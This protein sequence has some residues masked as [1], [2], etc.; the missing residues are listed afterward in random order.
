MPAHTRRTFLTAAAGAGALA[1]AGDPLAALR[2]AASPAAPPPIARD[3][4][5]VQGIASGE[6]ATDGITLWTRLEGLEQRSR[7][8][9]EISPDADFRRVIYRKTVVAEQDADFTIHHRATPKALRPGEEWHYRFFTCDQDSP[10]GRFR[11][12]VPADSQEPI[13]IGFYSCQ[14][15]AAGYYTAHAGLMNEP[16]LD[17]VVCLGDYIYERT[18]E[19]AIP[20]RRDRTGA[21]R[22]SLVETLPE[23]REKY[24][25]YHQDPDLLA[26]R[27]RF[28]M[29]ATWD[30]HE[31]KNN[32]AGP[33]ETP[34]PEK[35][36]PPVRRVSYA[37]RQ[38]NGWR[39]FFEHL[40]LRRTPGDPNRIYGSQRLGAN[41]ELM[42]LDERQYRDLQPCGGREI[43]PCPEQRNLRTLL[44]GP[45]K[46]WF[47]NA[48]AGSGATW[49]LVGNS[50]MIMSVDV[51]AGNSVN[52][53][54][55]DGYALEREEIVRF[56][57]ERGV[58]GVSFITGD[59]H[60]FFAG[61]VSPSGKAS[62][63]NGF[64]ATEFVCGSVTSKGIAEDFEESQTPIPG[65]TG[66]GAV[67]ANN[68]HMRYADLLRKGYGV[69]EARPEELLVTFRGPRT[70]QQ[71][72]SVVDTLA[73]FRVARGSTTVEQLEPLA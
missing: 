5:F 61:G 66:Q 54:Q 52:N 18:G 29:A 3:A 69:V 4:R 72:K 11:T 19:T 38:A 36:N 31:T 70:T 53:D 59:I 55:W 16:D 6:P 27:A 35:R 24:R 49:K 68:P 2:K 64:G 48:L 17:L 43:E 34:N 71:P 56:I 32:N 47:K 20:D 23:Y 62:D 10:V 65:L 58:G 57:Q 21:N 15:Y 37:D 7:L 46:E 13:R 73:R 28:P 60:S 41:V 22:D 39:A 50:V 44:G 1:M 40:P 25:L 45:Q 30:D 33:Q 63:P 26:V 42:M 67:I 8:Q 51:P 14:N 12:L 9:V